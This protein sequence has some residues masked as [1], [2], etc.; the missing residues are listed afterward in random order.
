MRCHICNAALGPEDVS[1][2]ELHDEFDPCPTCLNIISEVFN[3]RT[4]EEIT[5][6]LEQEFPEDSTTSTISLD[7]SEEVCYNIL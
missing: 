5:E 2:S 6:E 3:D 1:F 7:N 4:E